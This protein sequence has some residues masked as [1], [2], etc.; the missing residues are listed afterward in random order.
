MNMLV[1][2]AGSSSLK[3]GVFDMSVGDCRV[4][5]AEFERFEG[6]QCQLH[7]RLGGEQGVEQQRREPVADVEEAIKRVS[8]L[9]EEWGYGHIDA[10]SHRVV[11][12]GL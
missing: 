6:G 1:L 2:N 7:F 5:K 3:F 12:G 11:H 4:V 9:L 10:V 8:S